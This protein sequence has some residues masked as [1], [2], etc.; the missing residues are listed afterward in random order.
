MLTEN[1]LQVVVKITW[2]TIPTSKDYKQ[3]MLSENSLLTVL[4]AIREW[5]PTVLILSGE[6]S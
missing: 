4:N 2:E 6:E 5:I 1:S 3:Y